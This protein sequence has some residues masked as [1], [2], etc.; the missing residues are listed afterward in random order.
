MNAAELAGVDSALALL[1]GDV[2][3][4]QDL[5]LRRRRAWPSC[6]ERRV[7][8]DRVDQ[9][10]DRQQLLDL[11]A[12]QVADEVPLEGVAPALALGGE[13]LLAVLAD[14]GRPRPRPAPPSPRAAR[15]WSRRGSRP[16]PPPW[17]APARGWRRSCAG[18]RP[19]IR[20]GHLSRLPRARPGRPGARCAARRGGGRRRAPPR[21]WCRGRP[22]RPARPRPAQQ[23]PRDLGAGRASDPTAISVAE[24]G[25]R[26]E[27]LVADLVAAGA[28]P[29]ADR[30]VGR[31]DRLGAAGDDPGREP[32][33][34]AVQHRH[35]AGAGEGDRQAVG[36]EDERRA[37]P[38]ALARTTWP[39]TSG[40]SAPGSAK[41]LG[42]WAAGVGRAAR[43]RGPGGRSPP[44]RARGRAPPRGGGGSR[45][46]R[47][48]RRR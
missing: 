23:A 19:W 20:L 41:G 27:H 33:P 7:A 15:T 37:R 39:S 42:L 17:P 24:V 35:S 48:G 4:D 46:R 45:P 12:L 36:D 11:A 1:A 21:S 16:P 43:R 9:A 34:A 26:L 10:A 3:L 44:A 18:S 40:I 14:Q 30:G 8:G 47:R 38:G 6:G 32:A 5:G 25:E 29:R 22:T 31:A 28:D 2:D 13:V